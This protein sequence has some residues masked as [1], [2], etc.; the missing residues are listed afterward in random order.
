[1]GREIA[2]QYRKHA[3]ELRIVACDAR[4]AWANRALL[5]AADDYDRL[6]TSLEQSHARRVH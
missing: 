6:A 4:P 3:E 5:K 1:M 2:V